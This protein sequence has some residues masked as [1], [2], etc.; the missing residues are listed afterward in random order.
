[1]SIFEKRTNYKPFEYGYITEPLI[2]A[3]WAGHWTH[4]EF[5]FKDDVQDF[6]TKLTPEQ[7]EILIRSV[8]LTSQIEVA[9][10]SYWTK[11]GFI[12]PKPEFS[13]MGAVLEV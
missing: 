1:M 5:N 10:K 3:M 2:D 9:V 4:N 6:K 8:L 7:Q 12:F 13:D 11:L